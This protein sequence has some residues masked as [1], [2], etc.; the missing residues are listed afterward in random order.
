MSSGVERS[1]GHQI[2]LYVT[3]C[4]YIQ[5]SLCM[6]NGSYTCRIKWMLTHITSLNC[7]HTLADTDFLGCCTK[8]VIIVIEL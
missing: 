8:R 3:Q 5:V 1:V 2:H 4:S 6:L 7:D